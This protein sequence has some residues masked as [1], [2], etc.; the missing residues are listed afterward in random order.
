MRRWAAL[1]AVLTLA[2]FAA[3]AA[4][5]T[6]DRGLIKGLERKFDKGIEAFSIDDPFYLLGNTR[7]V[8]LD[9]Y[10][11][12]FTAEL[13]LVAAAVITPFRP[14]F[15]PEQIEKLRQKKLT[16]LEPLKK[17]MRT[18][19][20]DS[21]TSLKSV[22]ANENIAVGVSLFYY[23]WEDTRELPSQV[24]MEAR[25]GSLLDFETGR[26]NPEQL[27]SAIRVQEF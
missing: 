7:G 5:P 19:M 17:V 10:G 4:G 14:S 3:T 18:M 25:R 24:L 11:A 13:N 15:T 8:Y 20:V 22:P 21:A 23:S 9:G 2:M 26:L 12:V 16:R 1:V 6:M 27:N